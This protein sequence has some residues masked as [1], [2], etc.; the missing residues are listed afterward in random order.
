MNQH[1]SRY[2]VGIDLGTTTCALSYLDKLMPQKSLQTLS[3]PQWHDNTSYRSQNLLP[4]FCF[5]PPKNW[6][7]KLKEQLP[8]KKNLNQEKSECTYII[9][10]LAK[11]KSI[12][13]PEH[14]I[15]SAKSWLTHPHIDRRAPILPWKSTEI[16]SSKQLSPVECSALYL[17]YLQEVWNYEKASHQSEYSLEKQDIIITIPAS[18]D[19]TASILTLEAAE[20]S[21]LNIKK[22]RLVEEPQAAFY[23]WSWQK[24]HEEKDLQEKDLQE[25][26]HKKF[27]D[28]FFAKIKNEN[29]NENKN[30][31]KLL[32]CDIG[33]GTTDFSLFS[34]KSKKNS[35]PSLKRISISN[36]ILLGGDNID[37]KIAYQ[38]EKNLLEQTKKEQVSISLWNEIISQARQ[39]KESILEKIDQQKEQKEQ[40]LHIAL[41]DKKL[42]LFKQNISIK[43]SFKEIKE[44]ILEGFFPYCER[45]DKPKQN[46]L[47]LQEL[48]LAYAY[49]SAITRHLADFLEEENVDA[50]LYTGGSLKPKFIRSRISDQIK[51]WQGY[52]PFVL[53][54]NSMD[55]AVAGGAA[56]YGL[57]NKSNKKLIEAGYPRSLYIDLSE[58]KEKT[59]KRLLCLLP[60]GW[61]YKEPTKVLVPKLKVRINTPVSFQ[62]YS[63]NKRQDKLAQI[64]CTEENKDLQALAPLQ[65]YLEDKENKQGKSSAGD[66]IAI[67]L[68]VSL[69]ETG[70]LL[71]ECISKPHELKEVKRWKLSFNVQENTVKKQMSSTETIQITKSKT[72]QEENKLAIEKA[73]LLIENFYGLIKKQRL[74]P[75]STSHKLSIQLEKSLGLNKFAWDLQTLRSLWNPLWLAETKRQRSEQDESSWLNIAGFSLRPGYG[76][77]LDSF[78]TKNV[79]SL[80]H[81]GL[82]HPKA[83]KA[84]IQWLIFWR[85]I[86]G[87][88]SR[89]QQIILFNKFFPQIR[90]SFIDSIEIILL[91]GS[92]EKIDTEYKVKLGNLL[93]NKLLEKKTLYQ[94]ELLWALARVANRTPITT[95]PEAILA[96]HLIETWYQKLAKKT[97]E[98]VART[99]WQ[100]FLSNAGRLVDN[101]YLDINHQLREEWIKILEEDS[102]PQIIIKP[103]QE[104]IALDRDS[105]QILL[106]ESLPPGFLLEASSSESLES[107]V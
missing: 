90:T 29:K 10:E 20:K 85:R 67:E 31:F 95:G 44:L 34:L 30:E 45:S 59:N 37:I 78:R 36:H 106:G 16:N 82:K 99:N 60:K 71:L 66:Y 49:D 27:L 56:I 55:L 98:P 64:I 17:K 68:E 8:H 21:G 24:S 28:D 6:N 19:E 100:Q 77:P 96:P 101:R 15:Q 53:E 5:I 2:I 70:L 63:S 97:W 94:K 41:R 88:L 7:K 104:K 26:C 74:S 35:Y 39:I 25:K 46:P 87:G 4:S 86:S 75:N 23:H 52:T 92:L 58:D 80:F 84:Q 79:W 93:V 73:K 22:I 11:R 1:Q 14:V 3:I 62:I 72:A 76:D 50:L 89:K 33:G 69:Q 65:T 38:I 48:G 91:L 83:K 107:F 57:E 9:G 103:L 61:N 13:F 47:A 54:N 40:N 12:D 51:K 32:V 42:S 105:H 18:F 102:A 81:F 43:I